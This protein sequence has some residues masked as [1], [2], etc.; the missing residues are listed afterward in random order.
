M[1]SKV[2]IELPNRA[3]WRGS[4]CKMQNYIEGLESMFNYYDIKQYHLVVLFY[5]GGN[6]FS[7]EI[8]NVYGVEI[9]YQVCEP[10]S[11]MEGAMPIEAVWFNDCYYFTTDFEVDKLQAQFAF[12]C[13][14]NSSEIFELVIRKEHLKPKIYNQVSSNY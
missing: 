11:V 12:N 13:D 5:G 2:Y 6:K 8:F 10:K 4:Y 9:F 7:L 3:L 14:N 1:P